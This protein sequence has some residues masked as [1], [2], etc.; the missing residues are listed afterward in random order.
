[1]RPPFTVDLA[2]RIHDR[3]IEVTGGGSALRD[4]GRLAALAAPFQTF[5]G[6]DLYPHLIQKA[7]ALA[8][9]IIQGH[10][11]LDGNKRTAFVHGSNGSSG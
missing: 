3:I 6:K 9:G 1:V 5:E 11:F 7:A 8:F 4:P 2:S 10:P